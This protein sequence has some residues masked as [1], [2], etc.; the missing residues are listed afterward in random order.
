MKPL[1]AEL[2]DCL[3]LAAQGEDRFRGRCEYGRNGRIFGGQV[4]AQALMAAGRTVTDR[5]AHS[6]QALFLRMGDPEESIEFE[7][8]RLRDGRSFAARRVLARQRA[9][10]IFSLQASFHALEPGFEHQLPAPQAPDPDTMPTAQSVAKRAR[11]HIPPETAAW[12]CRER[13]V[14]IRHT[15]LPSYLGGEASHEPN[16]AWFRFEAELPKDPLLH[17]CLLAYASDIALNDTAYRPHCGPESPGLAAMSSVD[18]S[19]WFHVPARADTWTLYQQ[20]SPRAAG[21]RG[22]ANGAMF[23]QDGS[24][25]ASVGQDSVMRPAA[26]G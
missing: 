22:Y 10:V 11:A 16:L 4:V 7:V 18:H 20:Q 5:P 14:E 2:L 26:P 6:L 21:A 8:E 12:A 17:Q 24:R 25:I 19:L 3:D 9:G 1:L 13:P 15:V 23:E